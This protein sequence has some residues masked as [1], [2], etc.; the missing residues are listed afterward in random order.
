MYGYISVEQQR[1][2]GEHPQ[3][4]LLDAIVAAILQEST[5]AA[6]PAHRRSQIASKEKAERL[7][8]RTA[9]GA[10]RFAAAQPRVVSGRPGLFAIVVFPDHVRGDRKALEIFDLQ[11]RF[12]MRLRQLFERVSPAGHRR[13]DTPR[14]G[15]TPRPYW[16]R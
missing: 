6:D 13:H 2:G 1:Q 11:P 10:L 7:P 14:R 12:P 5:A 15:P 16:G 3:P 8:E 9:C 4:G